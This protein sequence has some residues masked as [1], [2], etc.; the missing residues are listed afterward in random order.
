MKRVSSFVGIFLSWLVASVGFAEEPAA[1]PG[2]V[3]L[4]D[5]AVLRGTV[6]EEPGRVI[7]QHQGGEIRLTRD[8]VACWAESLDG[9]YQYQLDR[10]RVFTVETYVDA[11][12][13]CLRNGLHER[14][15]AELVAAER[16]DPHHP[17]IERTSRELRVAIEREEARAQVVSDDSSS[18][19]AVPETANAHTANDLLTDNPVRL[20]GDEAHLVREFT[21]HIQPLLTNR[22]NG[23][24][25]HGDGSSTAFR[26]AGDPLG[27][28]RPAAPETWRN[29]QAALQWVDPEHPRASPLLVRAL[30]PHGG[31]QTPPLGPRE[32]AAVDNLR[33]WISSLPSGAGEFARSE[34]DASQ[35]AAQDQVPKPASADDAGAPVRLPGV[36]DPFDPEL[37]NR[38]FRTP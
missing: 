34:P 8:R 6:D 3:L 30:E 2:Y 17:D 27:G 35:L 18:A 25:C 10:R 37:F 23:A 32:Q 4:R 15:A 36:E 28:G 16:V 7:I 9:L 33:R 13:W 21:A 19:A 24:A 20:E 12:R 31:S 26:L 14:A 1:Q 38:R 11:A 5:G 22:C 29:L